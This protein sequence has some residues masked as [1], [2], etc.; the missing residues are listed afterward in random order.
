MENN[1]N[2]NRNISIN[3]ATIFNN[4]IFFDN[5]NEKISKHGFNNDIKHS[6]D[7][8]L[9]LVTK[10]KKEEW[11]EKLNSIFNNN[12]PIFKKYISDTEIKVENMFLHNYFI[13][14]FDGGIVKIFM[15]DKDGYIRC[16]PFYFANSIE[17]FNNVRNMIDEI[18]DEF[19]SSHGS[20]NLIKYKWYEF[21]GN[22][23]KHREIEIPFTDVV[24]SEAYP[25][26]ANLNEFVDKFFKSTSSVLILQGEPGVGKTVFIR[27]MINRMREHLGDTNAV[28]TVYYT[29]DSNVI[30]HSEFFMEGLNVEKM[31]CTVI[32]DLDFDLMPRQDDNPT[33]YKLLN[34]TDGLV[35]NKM[36]L[37]I[38]TNLLGSNH[39]DSALLRPGRCF[40]TIK[41]TKLNKDQSSELL[42]K[43]AT[44]EKFKSIKLTEDS[45]TL[46]ELYS[47]VDD[48][49][50]D[51]DRKV[52]KLGF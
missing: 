38:S 42:K 33:M 19:V 36:K 28:P 48:E 16:I 49:Y 4:L 32:E 8:I 51:D 14:L 31:N 15:N 13:S 5:V 24:H 20:N 40:G 44:P 7:Y 47:M 9:S 26:I 52:T 41:L 18:F 10:L 3:D 45:Y 46:A 6:N 25:K 29:C 35:K 30:K 37:I 39:I 2:F 22:E 17:L 23:L 12:N 21:S 27:Y 43:I 50:Y 34:T 11:F 1:N